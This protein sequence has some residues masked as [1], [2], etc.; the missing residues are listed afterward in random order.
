M[1]R[2]FNYS[3]DKFVHLFFQVY[4]CCL[5]LSLFG[6][7]G[8][9]N[10]YIQTGIEQNLQMAKSRLT[11]SKQ[12][13]KIKEADA[14]RLPVVSFDPS[15][16]LAAGGRRINFPV[17]DLF[18]PAYRAL[19]EL[20]QSNNFPTDLE[21]VDEQLT[22]NNFHDLRVY[23]SYPLFNP[24]IYYNH[25]A[26][27]EL[28]SVEKAKMLAFKVDLAKNIKVAYYNYFKTFEVLSIFKESEN[29]LQEVHRFNE[30]LIKYDKATPDILASVNYEIEKIKSDRAAILQQQAA[31]KAYFNTLLNRDFE[32]AIALDSI[33]LNNHQ[34]PANLL[35]LRKLALENRPEFDQ[36]DHAIQATQQVSQIQEKSLLPTVALQG[37]AGF[38]GN[39]LKDI[40]DQ[41]LATLA[42]G[43]KWTIFDGKKRQYKIEQAKIETLEL[44]KEKELIQQQ[45]QLQVINA[46]HALNAVVQK[47]QSDQAAVANAQS[48][49]D[50]I[51]KRYENQKAIFIEYLDAQS[52]L[53]NAQIALSITKYDV[54]IRRAELDRAVAY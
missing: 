26:Q 54:L 28:I 18:N 17:G 40:G 3:T 44:Q 30:K 36:L 45:I 52:K 7:E 37:S 49:F 14:N 22:P 33:I 9:L 21:N 51:K 4:L 34:N 24:A 32:A 5:P 29:L 11:I 39:G 20:T 50:L 41:A 16:I 13:F 19:N 53:T 1:K 15:Y 42:I 25:K 47:L 31:A 27:E 8:I 46:W 6:Q 38:Q 48:N 10:Q 23:A 2:L 12:E 43:A 35:E